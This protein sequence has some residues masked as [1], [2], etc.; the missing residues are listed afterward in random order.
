MTELK[1][2]D[3]HEWAAHRCTRQLTADLKGDQDKALVDLLSACR[4]S[5]DP[6]VT[7][8]AMRYEYTKSMLKAM[9]PKPG[10]NDDDSD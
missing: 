10:G 6:R 8:A 1:G 9:E 4:A 5:T 7:A 2:P 3:A